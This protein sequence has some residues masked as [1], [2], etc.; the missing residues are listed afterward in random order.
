MLNQP[1]GSSG[2]KG[3]P[4]AGRRLIIPLDQLKVIPFTDH[5]RV[6]ELKFN[7]AIM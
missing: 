6:T 2:V 4:V 3:V 1:Q 5:K 7:L